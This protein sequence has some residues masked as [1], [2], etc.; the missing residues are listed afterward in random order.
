MR[1]R[2]LLSAILTALAAGAATLAI[3]ACGGES[4]GG[5]NE[6][7]PSTSTTHS[8]GLKKKPKSGKTSY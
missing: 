1:K 7:K 3:A 8:E 2:P 6:S 5:S 4:K